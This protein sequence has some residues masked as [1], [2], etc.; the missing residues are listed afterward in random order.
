MQIIDFAF[1]GLWALGLLI[2]TVAYDWDYLSWYQAL[3][4]QYTWQEA[5]VKLTSVSV[6]F[7]AT[8]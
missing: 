1:L 5:D 2:T 3:D 4:E 7:Y 6:L 8:K